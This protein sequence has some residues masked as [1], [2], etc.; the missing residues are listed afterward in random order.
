MHLILFILVNLH[1]KLRD[2]GL[3]YGM[4]LHL[5]QTFAIRATMA[6]KPSVINGAICTRISRPG[7][8]AFAFVCSL[9]CRHIYVLLVE[10]P[11]FKNVKNKH[12][13]LSSF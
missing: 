1:L 10:E 2:K 9:F 11:G 13:G 4:C 6:L 5:H 8:L 7:F 12:L 3:N